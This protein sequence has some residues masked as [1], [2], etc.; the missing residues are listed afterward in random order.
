MIMCWATA[1]DM[2]I[3]QKAGELLFF[4]EKY[5]RPDYIFAIADADDVLVTA[6]NS[7]TDVNYRNV[8]STTRV[9]CTVIQTATAGT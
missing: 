5:L 8:T 4:E 1:L 9:S 3:Q 7:D 2:L 6:L